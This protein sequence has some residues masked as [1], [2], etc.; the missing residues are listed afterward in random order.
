MVIRVSKNPSPIRRAKLHA[1]TS[2]VKFVPFADK[3]TLHVDLLKRRIIR[4]KR[5]SF[6][7]FFRVILQ[8]SATPVCA[9]GEGATI[10]TRGFRSFSMPFRTKKGRLFP[11]FCGRDYQI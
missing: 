2:F 4:M 3:R 9:Q 1:V 8:K 6:M 5:I 7:R 10:G 11:P